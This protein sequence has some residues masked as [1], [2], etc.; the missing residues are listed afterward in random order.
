MKIKEGMPNV[1]CKMAGMEGQDML[2]A[3]QLGLQ[4]RWPVFLFQLCN[5]LMALNLSV[6]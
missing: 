5:L 1:W 2:V 3:K 4:A 6:P